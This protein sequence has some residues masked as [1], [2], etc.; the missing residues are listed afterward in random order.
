MLGWLYRIFI[1]NFRPSCEH[2]WKILKTECH[3]IYTTDR[4]G[5]KHV[6]HQVTDYHQQCECCGVLKFSQ[7]K[8]SAS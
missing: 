2:T 1:G 4:D 6:K 3:D 5:D 8:I 7:T